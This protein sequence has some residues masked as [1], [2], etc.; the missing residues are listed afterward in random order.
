MSCY[1]TNII[2]IAEGQPVGEKLHC[3][4]SMS[5][6]GQLQQIIFF[7]LCLQKVTSLFCV[8][9]L[10]LGTYKV[11]TVVIWGFALSLG[12]LWKCHEVR[13]SPLGEIWLKWTKRSSRVQFGFEHHGQKTKHRKEKFRSV[14]WIIDLL[15]FLGEKVIFGTKVWH[16]HGVK[17]DGDLFSLQQKLQQHSTVYS[18]F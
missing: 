15:L 9:C 3:F 1:M 8:Q 17:S 14:W 10:H 7:I 4:A 16:L 5:R 12:N 11:D 13:W 6:T 18:L 2:L